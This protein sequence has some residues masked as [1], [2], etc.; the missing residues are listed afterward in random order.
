MFQRRFISRVPDRKKIFHTQKTLV[1][2]KHFHKFWEKGILE[3]GFDIKLRLEKGEKV[4][5]F[6]LHNVNKFPDPTL[7]KLI[8]KSHN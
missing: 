1:V 8:E 6:S 3:I 4:I 7:L 2:L 5:N